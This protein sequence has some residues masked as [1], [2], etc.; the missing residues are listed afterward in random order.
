MFWWRLGIIGW[1]SAMWCELWRLLFN[2]MFCLRTCPFFF[3]LVFGFANWCRWYFTD[4][5]TRNHMNVLNLSHIYMPCFQMFTRYFP[6]TA[7]CCWTALCLLPGFI[8]D[9]RLLLSVRVV[10]LC[11]YVYFFASLMRLGL[12]T[13]WPLTPRKLQDCA[14]PTPC[15]RPSPPVTSN[16]FF[17]WAL[18]SAALGQRTPLQRFQKLPPPSPPPAADGF[19][20]SCRTF[21]C[22]ACPTDQSCTLVSVGV[23]VGQV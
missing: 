8:W 6:W 22:E 21:R 15:R 19:S 7:L 3:R 1:R 10:C 2:C 14:R 16:T 17:L 9:S 20:G 18:I 5:I 13:L 12:M 23:T 4:L 11:V